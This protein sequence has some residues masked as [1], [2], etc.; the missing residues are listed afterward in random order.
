MKWLSVQG[1]GLSVLCFRCVSIALVTHVGAGKDELCSLYSSS[2]LFLSES[3]G[4]GGGKHSGILT[5]L[6][7]VCHH[8]NH[9]GQSVPPF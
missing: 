6:A 1:G 7:S 9:F 2:V 8:F 3:G 5:I 4:G